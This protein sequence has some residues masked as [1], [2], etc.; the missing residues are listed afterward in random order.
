MRRS[1]L[2]GLLATV[3]F[4]AGVGG[5]QKAGMV[6]STPAFA[7]GADIPQR[8]SQHD[9]GHPISPKLEWTNV[10]AATASFVLIFHDPDVAIDKRVEDSLHWIV[11]NIPGMARGLPESVPREPKLADGTIQPMNPRGHYG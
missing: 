2:A 8:Y 3:A 4:G 11:F 5:Q 9:P 7:D 6:L 10:P 1:I